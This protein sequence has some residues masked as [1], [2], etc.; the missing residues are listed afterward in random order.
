MSAHDTETLV[1][2]AY[3]LYN[4]RDFARSAELTQP[5]A[6]TVM[7]PTGQEFRGPEGTVAYLT[8]WA[9][10]FPD[11]TV[12]V[13]NVVAGEDGGAVEFIGQGTHTG[14]LVTP[15]GIIPP[16]GRRVEFRLCDVW[17]VRDGKFAGNR[18]YFDL[19]TLLGQLDVAPHPVG[20]DL[21]HAQIGTVAATS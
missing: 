9:T 6:V 4:R 20:L 11:S 5:D 21:T 10:A 12:E 3:D 8:G 13:L 19:V 7:V 2:L 17:T 18:N 1:R 15:A 14:P 16:T